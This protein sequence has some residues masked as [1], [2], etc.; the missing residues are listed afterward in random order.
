MKFLT[1]SLFIM[2]L[3][4][5]LVSAN[6]I[7]A[8]ETLL[9]GFIKW[10]ASRV[11]RVALASAINDIAQDPHI[12]RYFPLT[13]NGIKLY[14]SNTSTRRL[15]P[16][17]QHNIEQDIEEL[18]D[19]LSSC[20][21]SNLNSW[22]EGLD[23]NSFTVNA[24]N[25]L[26][27]NISEDNQRDIY[28]RVSQLLLNL[29]NISSRPGSPYYKVKKNNFGGLISVN[30]K[31]EKEA[32]D[33]TIS[34]FYSNV[35][36]NLPEEKQE[37]NEKLKQKEYVAGVV[38]SVV[39]MAAKYNQID[40]D[41]ENYKS[42]IKPL[43]EV[44]FPSIGVV[45]HEITSYF[46]SAYIKNLTGALIGFS[47]I[48]EQFKGNN[49]P[50]V[51]QVTSLFSMIEQFTPPESK[52]ISGFIK[53]RS[54]TIFLASLVDA[55]RGGDPDSVVA[56]LDSYVD[57]I[58]AMNRKRSENSFFISSIDYTTYDDNKEMVKTRSWWTG[59][60]VYRVFPCENTIFIGSYYGFSYSNHEK[61]TGVERD[62]HPR[63]FGPVGVELKLF[64]F[65]SRPVTL[66]YAPFDIGNY[67]TNELSDEEYS[68][69]FSDIVAPSAF[70]S[71][72]VKGK[73]ISFLIGYQWDMKLAEDFESEGPFIS[74]AYDLPIFGLY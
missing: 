30:I 8:S 55:G 61:E 50:F 4:G 22:V 35:C 1:A 67:V 20:I 73:P 15:I 10:Q 51:V 54:T 27:F 43:S 6:E 34:K 21:P 23:E 25:T 13:S 64:S 39:N 70:L 9:K 38:Y 2:F 36:P 42:G 32:G 44:K 56:V 57:D 63:A 29:Y 26:S 46:T 52:D 11:E 41:V 69:K 68:A 14:G 24:D 28:I 16:L 5:G 19:I 7:S 71:Y 53:L 40:F 18:N 45:P 31:K 59:C 65:K 48:N 62:W 60:H 66:M 33:Y 74:I 17:M 49:V 12:E 47:Q 58:D 72:T 37:L 3:W